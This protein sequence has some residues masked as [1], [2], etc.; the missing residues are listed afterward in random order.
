MDPAAE[1]VRIALARADAAMPGIAYSTLDAALEL[2]KGAEAALEVGGIDTEHVL[3]EVKAARERTE[4]AR[5][6]TRRLV[7]AQG[8]A[9]VPRS[10]G[11]VI[12]R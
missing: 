10:T 11:D 5:D 1:Q 12:A 6:M 8:G 7:F 2:L 3:P 4:I 9:V